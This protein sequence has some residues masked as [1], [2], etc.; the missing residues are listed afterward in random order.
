MTIAFKLGFA[1]ALLAVAGY[2][3][4]VVAHSEGFEDPAWVANMPDNWQ[5][6]GGAT[7]T[8]ATSGTNGITY[9]ATHS[10]DFSWKQFGEQEA[11]GAVIG[12]ATAG[13]G[14][15]VG[16]SATA[17]SS[18]GAGSSATGSG[19]GGGSS[20][21]VSRRA[22]SMRTTSPGIQ[23]KPSLTSCSRPRLAMSCMPTQIPRNG[24]ARRTTSSSRVSHMPAMANNPS[25]QSLNA[26]T[27]GRTTRSAV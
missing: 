27:P 8:R 21:I 7:I 1:T 10:S 23:S 6:L 20:M 3:H 17:G 22:G 5:N 12:F 2:G 4:A 16:S 9:G 18:A 25:R 24:L 13:I 19:A 14:E 15:L 26:P 11:E